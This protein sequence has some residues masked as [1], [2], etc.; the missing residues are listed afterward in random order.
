MTVKGKWQ[1]W[2]NVL[3]EQKM[4]GKCPIA[5]IHPPANKMYVM[6]VGSFD[7]RETVESIENSC[8]FEASVFI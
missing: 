2:C 4:R 5:K 1:I 3:K 8:A 6:I 7:H